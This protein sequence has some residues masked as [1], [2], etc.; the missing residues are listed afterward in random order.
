[1]ISNINTNYKSLCELFNFS[2]E[3]TADVNKRIL[4]DMAKNGE[5][6]PKRKTKTGRL[7]CSYTTKCEKSYD[8]DF[9]K[10]IKSARPD[11][12]CSNQSNENKIKLINMARNNKSRPNQ[13]TRIGR[14]LCCYTNDNS[15]SCDEAF[16]N[17]IRCLRPDWFVSLVDVANKK[18]IDLIKMAKSGSLRP[19][20]KTKMGR[21]L[22]NY[23]L[24]SSA[25]YDKIF[26]SKIKK[27]I[28]VWFVSRSELANQN[29][30]IL[31]KMAQEGKPRPKHKTKINQIFIGRALFNYT[32]LSQDSYDKSF[33]KQI[34]KIRPDWFV[35]SSDVNKKKLIKLAK[36]GA[37]KP[38]QTTKMGMYLKSYTNKSRNTYCPVF[39]KKIRSLRPDWFKK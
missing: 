9:E 35:K 23:T 21:A 25:S 5:D 22:C 3:N 30:Q 39:Y 19:N 7:L 15:K 36:S 4:L 1:M 11:W 6:R 27:I 8:K 37:D 28:P 29:K 12:F 34:K 32:N 14:A 10:T 20:S 17:K 38:F 26:D 13:T 18:K 33:S 24:K 16:N 31:I 2:K